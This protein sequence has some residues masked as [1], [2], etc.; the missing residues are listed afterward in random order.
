[1]KAKHFLL[2]ILLGIIFF[3]CGKNSSS[4]NA[5]DVSGIYEYDN[6]GNTLTFS[7]PYPQWTYMKLSPKELSLFQS[8]DTASLPNTYIP[9]IYLSDS[10]KTFE[11]IFYPNPIHYVG[12]I[13]LAGHTPWVFSNLIQGQLLFKYVLVDGLME[14]KKKGEG[15][16]G[17]NGTVDLNL[18]IPVGRYRLYYTLSALGHENFYQGWGNVQRLE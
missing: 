15:L 5:I 4:S 10:I 17:L 3:G 18:N 11:S 16:I 8:L 12:V 2:I 14:S 7:S 9:P 6:N 13:N 1:M